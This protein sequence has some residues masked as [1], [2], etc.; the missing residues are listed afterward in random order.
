MLDQEKILVSLT[1]L[2]KVDGRDIRTEDTVE[3]LVDDASVQ[4]NAAFSKL[5]HDIGHW[6]LVWGPAIYVSFDRITPYVA[7]NVIYIAR[8][9]DASGNPG[10][11]YFIGIAGTNPISWYG[12]LNEDFAVKATYP[13]SG[14]PDNGYIAKGTETG[15]QNLLNLKAG[16][17]N[18]KTLMD[19]LNDEIDHQKVTISFGGHSLGG[20]LAPVLALYLIEKKKDWKGENVSFRV[21]AYAGATPGD[22]TFANH[23]RKA[24]VN[25]KVDFG[26]Y[27]NV[28]DIVP[29]AWNRLDATPGLFASL[30]PFCI[31]QYKR[32]N[33]HYT[34]MGVI[35]KNQDNQL[36]NG[37]MKWAKTISGQTDYTP[38]G[39][40]HN[41]PKNPYSSGID[42][43]N[44]RNPRREGTCCRMHRFVDLLLA[45]SR[46]EKTIGYNLRQIYGI[47]GGV[48]NLKGHTLVTFLDFMAEAGHQHTR[49]YLDYLLD[50]DHNLDFIN[51]LTNIVDATS[52]RPGQQKAQLLYEKRL[53]NKFTE[54]IWKVLKPDLSG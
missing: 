47:M 28:L 29:K 50:A 16:M 36:I 1:W 44:C 12:W 23:F 18:P 26:A 5:S 41:F 42:L 54:T 31:C 11:N 17:E 32:N 25:N 35:N 39:S 3:K 4:I 38:L 27:N 52:K 6:K 46:I 48:G 45:E 10:P 22:K 14:R 8:E 13:W 30:H 49:A 33:K 24:I 7:D 19:F 51:D 43:D 15:L 40:V 9:M 21:R 37:L 53:L 20:T 2:S 34:V